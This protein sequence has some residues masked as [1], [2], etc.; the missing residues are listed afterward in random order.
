[1]RQI[2]VLLF[3]ATRARVTLARMS[4]ALA[5]QMNGF[6]SALCVAMYS[7]MAASDSGTL[8]NTRLRIR[9]SVMS[10]KNRSTMLSHD[11]LVGVKCIWK[12]GCLDSHA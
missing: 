10:R 1:M 7:L 11:A 9:L 4:D 8:L 12:R 2:E 3:N 5:V 6:G